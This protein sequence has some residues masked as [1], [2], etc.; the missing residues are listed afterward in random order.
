M[1][2]YGSIVPGIRSCGWVP[3]DVCK[4]L[5]IYCSKLNGFRWMGSG[6]W[7]PVKLAAVPEPFQ[8]N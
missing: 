2:S 7:V 4:V 3:V 6:G 1:G 5:F 8:W